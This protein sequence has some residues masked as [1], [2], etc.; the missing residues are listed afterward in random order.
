METF[1]IALIATALLAYLLVAMLRP[2][3]F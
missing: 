1:L 2:E 3:K